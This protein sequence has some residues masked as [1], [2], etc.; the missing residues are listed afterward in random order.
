LVEQRL[1]TPGGAQD[2]VERIGHSQHLVL[3]GHR[4]A[5]RHGLRV[6]VRLALD[7]QQEPRDHGSQD[8]RQ[9]LGGVERSACHCCEEVGRHGCLRRF[10]WSGGFEPRGRLAARGTAKCQPSNR[11]THSSMSA[12]CLLTSATPPLALSSNR[13]A[14]LLFRDRH[15]EAIL[16]KESQPFV[17]ADAPGQVASVG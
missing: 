3:C 17:G 13:P 6:H 9:L 4:G 11:V 1:P 8:G 14:C 16:S 7:R 10:G 12:L 15:W 5:F 2:G